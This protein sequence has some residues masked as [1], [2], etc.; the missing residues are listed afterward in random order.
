MSNTT[1]SYTPRDHKAILKAANS[2]IKSLGIQI[3]AE[4]N[5]NSHTTNICTFAVN[6]PHALIRFR[7]F[8]IWEEKKVLVHSYFY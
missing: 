3:D 5:F 1:I 8:L 7:K 4:L 6:Q 2:S